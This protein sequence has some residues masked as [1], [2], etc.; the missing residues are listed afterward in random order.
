MTPHESMKDIEKEILRSMPVRGIDSGP[1]PWPLM[2][3]WIAFALWIGFY[4]LGAKP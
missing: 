3:G 2:I 4:V 1:T